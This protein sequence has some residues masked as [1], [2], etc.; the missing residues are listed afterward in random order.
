M[1]LRKVLG[2]GKA[3]IIFRV[4]S[5]FNKMIFLS[6]IIAFPISYYAIKEWLGGFTFRIEQGVWPFII[7]GVAS[8]AVA[9][10]TVSF[11]VLRVANINPVEFLRDE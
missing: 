6:L 9:W 11:Q 8:F 4:S 3:D 2:S 1:S 5:E 10:L 7:T